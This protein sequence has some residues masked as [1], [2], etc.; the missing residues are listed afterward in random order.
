MSAITGKVSN[1]Q[2]RIGG[3][4]HASYLSAQEKAEEE[5]ARFQEKNENRQRQK[6]SQEKK[7]ERQK[8]TNC[9]KTIK[10]VFSLY[11]VVLSG[12]DIC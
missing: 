6:G 9:I 1:I 4:T 3:A 7:T 11:T 12:N 2:H 10:V 8:E 5:G